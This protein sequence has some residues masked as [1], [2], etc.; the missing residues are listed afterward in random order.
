MKTESYAKHEVYKD[1]LLKFPIQPSIIS[2]RYNPFEK[3]YEKTSDIATLR[4]SFEEIP[5]SLVQQHGKLCHS[6]G[7]I[8]QN[9]S[10]VL[11]NPARPYRGF[12]Y[13]NK[14]IKASRV[15][16]ELLN[17]NLLKTESK[18]RN[19]KKWLNSPYKI[20]SSNDSVGISSRRAKAKGIFPS[21][22]G[23]SENSAFR[24]SRIFGTHAR[25]IPNLDQIPEVGSSRTSNFQ[26]FQN[27]VIYKGD[28][29]KRYPKPPGSLKNYLI[30]N[31]GHA[32]LK[33]IQFISIVIILK[34]SFGFMN[35]CREI[36]RNDYFYFSSNSLKYINDLLFKTFK[37]SLTWPNLVLGLVLF[38][39]SFCHRFLLAQ[40]ELVEE[41]H[42]V[43]Y[44]LEEKLFQEKIVDKTFFDEEFFKMD[45]YNRK[46]IYRI[47]KYLYQLINTDS[48]ILVVRNR[49]N[50]QLFVLRN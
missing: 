37:K 33:V 45:F 10:E 19:S 4:Y 47:R 6:Q 23:F 38:V 24:N 31:F 26:V 30:I 3:K 25:T 1:K 46:K 43:Y 13:R 40:K 2:K 20:P 5:K 39:F 42:I 50:L 12:W 29:Y 28:C 16:E 49:T 22:F 9:T 36:K 35:E 15:E 27:R 17:Q 32:S 44:E 21:N 41:A 48:R 7:S 14:T 18:A 8:N 34:L 11:N